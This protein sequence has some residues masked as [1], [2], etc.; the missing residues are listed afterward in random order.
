LLQAG[1]ALTAIE[2]DRDLVPVLEGIGHGQ[3]KV[4]AGNAAETEFARA[5]QVAS[6]KVV[7]N[8]PYHLTSPI[9]VLLGM[10]FDIEHLFNIPSG[11]FHPPPKVDSSVIRLTTLKQP[12]AQVTSAERFTRVVKAAFAQRRK[13]LLNSLQSDKQLASGDQIRAALT[14]AGIDPT[15]RAETLSV[16]EFAALQRALG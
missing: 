9:L 5:A 10:H 12:R 16:E 3:L 15:R 11:A 1:A 7:G 2:R 4:I 6:V 8:L 14:R 13:T